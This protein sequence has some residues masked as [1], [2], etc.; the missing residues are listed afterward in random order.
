MINDNIL[1]FSCYAQD[2]VRLTSLS[3]D[4]NKFTNKEKFSGLNS[5]LQSALI[6]CSK[7][8]EHVAPINVIF[9]RRV[10]ASILRMSMVFV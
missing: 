5:R 9:S 10:Y 6:S 7:F 2:R 8:G 1:Y 4:S 3:C